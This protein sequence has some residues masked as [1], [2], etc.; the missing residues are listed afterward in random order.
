MSLIS[1][2][3]PEQIVDGILFKTHSSELFAVSK[4]GK[5]LGKT[6]R[7]LKAKSQGKYL[8]VSYQV[9]VDNLKKIRHKYIHRL[10]AETWLLKPENKDEVNHIDGNKLNNNYLNLEWVNRKENVDHSMSIG[11]IWN[12]PKI[13]E[14]GFRKKY[15]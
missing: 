6:G 10:V 11:L 9:I 4:C 1:K 8:I 12:T 7:I 2:L 13:G 14:K 5:V 15:A 3:K